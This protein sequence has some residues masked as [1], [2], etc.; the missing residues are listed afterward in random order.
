MTVAVYFDL[1]N[2]L[3][4]FDREFEAILATT[5]EEAGTSRGTA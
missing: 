4:T 3:V 1:D 2:T 5:L